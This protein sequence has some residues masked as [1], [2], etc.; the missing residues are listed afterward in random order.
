VSLGGLALGYLTY[1]NVKAGQPEPLQNLPAYSAARNRFYFDEL[2][3]VIFVRPVIW[4][5]E[6]FSKWM[7]QG[8]IDGILHGIARVSAVV[9]DV[10]RKYI[11]VP[12]INGFGDLVSEVVKRLG[13][14]FRTVQTGR[15]QQY[16]IL[17]LVSVA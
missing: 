1:R 7:D 5:S 11:D 14:L 10:L 9:G 6:V 3:N 2:Y 15:V 16:M 8:V 12:I 17:A 13:Y 4:I